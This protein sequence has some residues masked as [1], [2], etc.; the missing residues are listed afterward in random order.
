MNNPVE[1]MDFDSVFILERGRGAKY[2]CDQQI[3]PF[4][5]SFSPIT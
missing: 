5:S 4:L 2:C 3:N 1:P